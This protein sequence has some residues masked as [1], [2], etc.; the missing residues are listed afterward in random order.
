M[1][2]MQEFENNAKTEFIYNVEALNR[3]I[4]QIDNLPNKLKLH[5]VASEPVIKITE[6]I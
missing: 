5:K 4:H 1:V 6:I 3:G 2:S